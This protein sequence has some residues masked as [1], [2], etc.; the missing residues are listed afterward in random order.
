MKTKFLII[1]TFGIS[2]LSLN[3]W[4]NN[5]KKIEVQDKIKKDIS[6]FLEKFAPN[7]KYSIKVSVKPLK[8]NLQNNS[9]SEDLPFM[10]FQEEM[11]LDPWDNPNTSIYELYGR[12]EEARV[13][14][15]I[16]AKVK[17]EDQRKFKETLLEEVNLVPG[18]DL[19]NL[20]FISTPV[21][22][23]EFSINDYNQVLLLGAILLVVLVLGVGLNSLSRKISPGPT[24][25]NNKDQEGV[26]NNTMPMSM[27]SQMNVNPPVASGS[28]G[29]LTGSF[30][31][32]DPSKIHEVV[33][34]KI[35]KLIE[36]EFFPSMNDML[37]LEKLCEVNQSS[38]SFLIYEFPET[39]QRKIYQLGRGD[40]WFEGFSNVG[41]PSKEVLI[42]LDHMLR[43]RNLNFNAKFEELLIMSWRLDLKLVDF[44]KNMDKTQAFTL[45]YYLPKNISIPVAKECFPGSWGEI[46]SS[47]PME[48]LFSEKELTKFLK[49]A[50]DILPP[51]NFD[52]LQTFKNR[53]DLLL[54]LDTIEPHEEKEIYSVVGE[55]SDLKSVR[56][57]FYRF[58]ELSKED[59]SEIFK[60]FSL[61]EWAVA[62]FNIGRTEKEQVVSLMSDKEKFMF[63]HLLKTLDSNP[64]YTLEKKD[65]RHKIAKYV[66]EHMHMKETSSFAKKEE[67]YAQ[68]A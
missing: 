50:G 3:L 15:L 37:I 62:C 8:Q 22:V 5:A 53:K 52:S 12:I 25:V 33:Q 14:V 24:V 26:S 54:Y 6:I 48:C 40:M 67:S 10:E 58:F 28:A 65:L 35:K 30:Q 34:K 43:E 27:P 66:F 32:Q 51:L 29:E 4:A 20:D 36:S 39:I 7:T 9:A 63:S 46:L 47:R 19:V 17:I 57:P 2:L 11:I 55:E 49:L 23:K 1:M 56:P 31:V 42:S 41:L 21:L 44:V 64:D 16:D 68:A 38:F 60:T 61:N 18:R 45:L 13:S 59:R